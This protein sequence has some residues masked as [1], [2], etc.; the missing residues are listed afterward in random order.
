[1]FSK[2]KLDLRGEKIT[3]DEVISAVLDRF[4]D[5]NSE[6]FFSGIQKLHNRSKECIEIRG[7][8]T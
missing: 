3:T 6:Y 4:K 7:D 8:Y 2:L 5:K 1:L